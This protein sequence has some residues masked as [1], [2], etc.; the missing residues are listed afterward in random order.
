[1]VRRE[2]REKLPRL[3]TILGKLREHYPALRERYHIRSLSVFG[4]Y[5]RGEQRKKSDVDILWDY[6]Q[7]PDLFQYMDLE[8][9]LSA[10][11]G[12]KVDLVSRGTLRGEIGQQILREAV[13]V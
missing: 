2:A 3:E 4:S 8:E 7:T 11:L 12:L 6:E 9:E 13:S 10:I 5:A 1:M